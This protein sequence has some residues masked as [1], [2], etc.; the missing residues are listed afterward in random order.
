[1]RVARIYL[2]LPLILLLLLHA[3][4][5]TR[6]PWITQGS[7]SAMLGGDVIAVVD[8]AD[9]S[10]GSCHFTKQQDGSAFSFD[11]S[12]GL[13]GVQSCPANSEKLVGI[14]TGAVE[15][16]VS[17]SANDVAEQIDGEVRE[18]RFEA[19]LSRKGKRPSTAQR[20]SLREDL[21]RAA[22]Q[23]AGNLF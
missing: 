17:H 20:Q 11:V 4:A 3:S 1:M 18:Q 16:S 5:S 10:T 6:C 19:V 15:C 13:P 7:V 9:S 14:G 2:I 12:V 23:I 8:A 22:E 21:R